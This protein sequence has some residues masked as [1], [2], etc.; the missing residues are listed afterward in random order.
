M[1][2]LG[3]ALVPNPGTARA[4]AHESWPS[5]EAALEEVERV[6]AAGRSEEA[7]RRL[8]RAREQFPRDEAVVLALARAYLRDENDFWA[9]NVLRQYAQEEPPA[10][11]SL[12]MMAFVHIGQANLEQAS[13][14]LEDDRCSE[15]EEVRARFVVLRAY[16]ADKQDDH[17]STREL[18]A[19][20]RKA[21]RMYEE[22]R[23]L[24]G[25][26]AERHDPGRVP[27]VSGKIDLATGWTSNGLAGSPVDTE[28]TDTENG[29]LLATLD[30]RLRVVVPTG[31]AVRPTAEAQA[32]LFQ[33]AAR[34]VS[35]LSYRQ[36]TPRA[37]LM[38]GRRRFRLTTNYA[39]DAVQIQGGDKYDDGPIW[40]SQAHRGEYELEAGDRALLF[41]GAG[42]RS[43]REAGRTRVELDQGLGVVF[44]PVHMLRVMAGASF[45]W[46]HAKNDAYD[47]VGG[48]ILGQLQV[49]TPPGLTP[50]VQVT[51]SGDGYPRSAGYFAGSNGSKRRELL[52][53]AAGG[54]WLP[55]ILGLRAG[56]MYEFSH[57]AS[58]AAAY[59]FS[60][61][62]IL[63]HGT[64]TFDSAMLRTRIIG[65]E[66][67]VPMPYGVK[68]KKRDDDDQ[69]IRDLMRE[70]EAVRRGSSCLQ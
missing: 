54:L 57:R 32:R 36:L 19:K 50:R 70:D 51:L 64:W 13:E 7:L 59:E 26:L 68:A 48:T 67:R 66:R 6:R 22:D 14:L 11:L 60:D 21:R 34:D 17:E 1:L 10:C 30:A 43:F 18:I 15:P 24:L 40:Y 25:S 35:D 2:G 33:L 49:P 27:V 38:F 29:S 65:P 12:A 46:H 20:A 44:S 16:L 45:R 53:R 37:G 8:K 56:L 63:I 42:Q 69:R 47:L 5:A 55:S 58:T 3:A 62:R 23:A 52:V 41:G 61:H 31:V 39:F 9:L 4:E 28:S